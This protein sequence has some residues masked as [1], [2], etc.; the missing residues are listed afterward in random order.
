MTVSKNYIY[1]YIL[2]YICIHTY[3][4]IE[5]DSGLG[6]QLRE[7]GILAE[8]PSPVLSTHTVTDKQP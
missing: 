6:R 1:I 8:D 7:L 2:K 3:K 5:K 4:F